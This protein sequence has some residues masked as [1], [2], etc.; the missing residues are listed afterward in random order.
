M[1]WRRRIGLRGFSVLRHHELRELRH[2]LSS[3]PTAT[4]STS[5]QAYVPSSYAPQP[6][7]SAASPVAAA[8]RLASQAVTTFDDVL[9]SSPSLAQAAPAL[10]SYG[11]QLQQAAD[12]TDDVVLQSDLIDNANDVDQLADAYD[13]QDISTA[14]QL[15][16]QQ[17]DDAHVWLD[18]CTLKE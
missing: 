14:T 3:D 7:Q 5:Y 9:G 15:V 13:R 12:A 16:K 4:P 2:A 10:R 17:E 6:Q 1:A 8:C 18:Y 11:G